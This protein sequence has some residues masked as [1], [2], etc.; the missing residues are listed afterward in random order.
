MY[1]G[2][3]AQALPVGYAMVPENSEAQGELRTTVVSSFAVFERRWPLTHLFK[4]QSWFAIIYDNNYLSYVAHWI[5]LTGL[6]DLRKPRIAVKLTFRKWPNN[7]RQSQA[8]MCAKQ[9]VN[10]QLLRKKPAVES[11]PFCWR[12]SAWLKRTTRWYCRH[13]HCQINQQYAFK[14]PIMSKE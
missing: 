7:W 8:Y 14:F 6:N 9:E 10:E 13:R 4:L 1:V 11:A 5:Y 3:G 2:T 12:T